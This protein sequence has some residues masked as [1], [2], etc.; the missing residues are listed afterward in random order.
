M[1]VS[2]ILIKDSKRVL[3]IEP[4]PVFFVQSSA[5]IISPNGNQQKQPTRPIAE[6]SVRKGLSSWKLPICSMIF[7]KGFLENRY[8]FGNQ[9]SAPEKSTSVR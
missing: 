8:L 2:K 1:V 6:T 7:K 3:E 5:I 4:P 9:R